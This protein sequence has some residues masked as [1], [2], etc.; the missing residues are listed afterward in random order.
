MSAPDPA[1]NALAKESITQGRSARPL[2]PNCQPNCRRCSS[3]PSK[4][5]EWTAEGATV[6]PPRPHKPP[7]FNPTRSDV[8]PGTCSNLPCGARTL[9]SKAEETWADEFVSNLWLEVGSAG[10]SITCVAE[11][12]F[13][14][15]RAGPHARSSERLRQV[16]TQTERARS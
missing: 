3:G 16:K 9:I 6:V 5:P 7:S 8:S 12:A 14:E 2:Q 11:Q 4:G 10:A 15:P 13:E 1:P